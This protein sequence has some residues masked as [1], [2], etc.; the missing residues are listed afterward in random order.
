MAVWALVSALFLIPLFVFGFTNKVQHAL[1]SFFMYIGVFYLN[2]YGLLPVWIRKRNI[3][4]MLAGWLGLIILCTFCSILMNHLFDVYTRNGN[5]K[6][7][8]INTFLRNLLFAG[9]VLF[10]GVAF[11][12]IED[13]FRNERVKQKLE[14]EN[15]RTELNFLKSQVNPH[16]LFNTL[17]NI[18]ALAYRK[19]DDAAVAIMKLSEIMQYMLYGSKEERVAVSREIHF[20]YQL[21]ALQQLRVQ[22]PLVLQLS[23]TGDTEMHA[24]APLL[25]IPFVENIFK[26][27]VLNNE[28]SPVIIN[29]DIQDGKLLFYSRNK[30]SRGSKYQAGGIGM[31]NVRRRLELLYPGKH[32]FNINSDNEFYSVKLTLQLL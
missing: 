22:G 30:I 5:V 2:V 4:V 18:Y 17:N 28:R 3:W 13:W 20:I 24:I 23:V 15:L 1:L 27:G 19:S 21:I 26:H 7:E 10:V 12:S 32:E 6:L 11:R 9:I 31:V 16:F 25:L 14:N 29:I 8:M